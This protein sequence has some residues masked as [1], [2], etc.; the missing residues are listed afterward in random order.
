MKYVSVDHAAAAVGVS[1]ATIRN[2]A[3][4]GHITPASSRP[5][6]FSEES[7]FTLKNKM[8][9]DHFKK[10][11]TR[12]NKSSSVNSF[13]P[14][15]YAGDAEVASQVA[16]V[17]SYVKNQHLETEPVIFLAALRLLELR[18]EV[19]K[20]IF[21]NPFDLN[22]YSS[23][24][25]DSVKSV[26]IDWR[27]SL[28]I[29][30]DEDRYGNLCEILNPN[31][32][33][34]YLGLLYQSIFN[35]GDKSNQGSY[36]TPSRLVED[37]FSQISGEVRTFLDP[38]CGSG[39]YLLIAAKKFNISPKN[40]YG[41]DCDKVAVYI[42]KINMLLAFE[43]S[44]FL[45]Q[46]YCID[47]LSD[48]A[49]GEMFCETNNLIGRIDLIATNPPWGAYKNST[50]KNQF[51][52]RVRSGETFSLFLEK[53]INIL[54]GGGRLSF[55]LPESILKIR[56]HAD[57]REIILNETKIIN[58][59]S[60]GRQFTGVFT[61]VIRLDLE[62][63]TPAQ[64]WRIVVDANNKKSLIQQSRF[65]KNDDFTFDIFMEE[66]EEKLLDK[67]YAVPHATLIKNGEWA[68][69]VVTGDNKKY[70][71]EVRESGAEPIYRGS[72]VFEYHLGEPRSF[73]NFSPDA[74][75]QVAPERYFRASEKLIYKFISNK[76]V[77]AYD[78]KQQLTLNSANILIPVI[79][80]VGIKVALAFLNSSVFQYVFKKKFST[81]KV[82][83]GDL[84]KLPFPFLS[85]KVH[86]SI[87]RLVDDAIAGKRVSRE[88]DKLIFEAFGLS[89]E[90]VSS[91][92][93]S[94]EG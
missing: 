32:C 59:A 42:A 31:E 93:Q 10:L 8:G 71:L 16:R 2:W 79:P 56:I 12:A 13:L 35:E 49:T 38:C 23:W 28:I 29:S 17:I 37:S 94:I 43:N 91:V 57:I 3:R 70:V 83:R 72:D 68:L 65:K 76:L 63:Q 1:S 60:L 11:K 87:E 69:G 30:R 21:S 78:D 85:Q 67:I 26:I 25:R 41:F 15:E 40:I 44:R 74:F 61:P 73:I 89:Q 66:Q 62:K 14:D 33:D 27:S 64:D 52:G 51:P 58:I 39:K 54:R 7:I 47:S 82:L 77:F 88:I 50:N 81:H 55:I 80:G 20:E 6:M 84:E 92:I 4:A 9:T 75:Q 5:I 45:P 48:L 19:I 86:S 34:D 90:D 18:G 46:I 53:S 36:Y 24:L 22:S